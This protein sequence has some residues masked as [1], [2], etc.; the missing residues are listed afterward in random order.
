MNLRTFALLALASAIA[1]AACESMPT[2]KGD[3]DQAGQPAGSAR[4]PARPVDAT[5]P[6]DQPAQPPLADAKKTG[7]A[8]SDAVNASRDAAGAGLKTLKSMADESR[9]RSL[10]FD[11]LPQARDAT[12]GDGLA[13]VRVR[14]DQLRA[15]QPGQSLYSLLQPPDRVVWAVVS[16]GAV[17][18][19][20]TTELTGGRWAAS[21]HGGSQMIR[22]IAAA[23]KAMPAPAEGQAALEYIV[24]VPALNLLFAA[25]Q[26]QAGNVLLSPA[27]DDDALRLS[28]GKPLPAEDV[29]P[30]LADAARQHDGN[31]R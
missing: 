27:A 31:P 1:C 5:P 23:R 29:L 7:Q 15:F 11:S 24:S 14:L 2:S 12:V 6:P 21:R 25:R 3:G 28:A 19:S 17:R 9:I 8:V 13:V 30:R 22:T 18:S 10:G 26:D 20:V 4:P 16:G